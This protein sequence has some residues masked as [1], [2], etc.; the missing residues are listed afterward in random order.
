MNLRLKK[1]GKRES[2][3]APELFKLK[4]DPLCIR[5]LTKE[6]FSKGTLMSV[7]LRAIPFQYL[8]H[9]EHCHSLCGHSLIHSGKFPYSSQC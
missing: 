6:A 7:G 3:K 8:K 9:G 2:T 1:E 5:F 4:E